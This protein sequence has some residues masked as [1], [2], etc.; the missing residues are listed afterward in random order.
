MF[1]SWTSSVPNSTRLEVTPRMRAVFS[2][3]SI[4]RDIQKIRSATRESIYS[5]DDPCVLRAAAL[6]RVDHQRA[7]EQRDARETA[8]NELYLLAG[9]HEGSQVDVARRDALVDEGRAGGERQRRLGDVVRRIGADARAE[10]LDLGFLG[11]GPDE[12][13]VAA[14]A[15]DFLHDQFLEAVHDQVGILRAL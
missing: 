11:G 4:W 5:I 13:A 3:R 15:G 10:G 6:R 2:A 8:G 12:H 14:R 1:W 9:E 7:L